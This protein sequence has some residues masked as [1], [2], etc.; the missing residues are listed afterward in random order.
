[1][2]HSVQLYCTVHLADSPSV[3]E[4]LV[5]DQHHHLTISDQGIRPA[6]VPATG[7]RKA[8]VRY[9]P[10]ARAKPVPAQETTAAAKRSTG[11]HPLRMVKGLMGATGKVWS[12]L[13]NPFV[14]ATKS[15]LALPSAMFKGIGMKKN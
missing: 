9:P 1:M 15:L 8:E 13:A 4:G 2:S 5:R 7:E 10:C 3:R 6:P 14:K 12:F 11:G